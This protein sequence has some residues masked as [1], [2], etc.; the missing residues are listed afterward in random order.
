MSDT[1]VKGKSLLKSGNKVTGQ[2]RGPVSIIRAGELEKAGTTGT[3]AKGTFEGA[4]PNKFNPEKNDYFVRGNGDELY[5]LNGTWSLASQ[6][7]QLK[8]MEG[9]PV[10]IVYNG[11][12]ETKKGRTMHEFEVFITE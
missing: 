7:D 3:V 1:K 6:L 2:A 5:I 8:G 10:E 9:T 12:I 4:K 11:K